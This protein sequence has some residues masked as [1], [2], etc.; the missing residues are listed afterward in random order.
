MAGLIFLW[1]NQTAPVV[2]P[3]PGDAS[4]VVLR[5]T[6]RWRPPVQ[7]RHHGVGDATLTA[8]EHHGSGNLRRAGISAHL[9]MP[10]C[11]AHGR[12]GVRRS[13]AG[14]SVVSATST[15]G[16]GTRRRTG[17]GAFALALMSA[18]ERDTLV[19]LATAE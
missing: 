12:G 13:C 17:R 5:R 10:A 1:Q 9:G 7:I 4:P 18:D 11:T 6:R 15:Q 3:P 2:Q 8:I 14:S 19:A 16:S